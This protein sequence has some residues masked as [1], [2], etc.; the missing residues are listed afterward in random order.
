MKRQT[1][2]L[3]TCEER[4][5]RRRRHAQVPVRQH[6]LQLRVLVDGEPSVRVLHRRMSVSPS[7][8]CDRGIADRP[9]RAG[10]FDQE[11]EQ[12]GAA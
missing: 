6:H 1:T 4:D 12:I 2:L 11:E 9:V 5:D 3:A 8:E 10:S 7:H